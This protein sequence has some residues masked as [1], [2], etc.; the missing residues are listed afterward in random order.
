MTLADFRQT[1]DHETAPAGLGEHLL[2]MWYEARGEWE[3]AHDIAQ[4]VGT[5]EG[6]WIHAYLYRKEGDEG[7]AAYWYRRAGRPFPSGRSLDEEWEELVRHFLE[8]GQ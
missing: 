1:L 6:D 3:R 8:S 7:N 5:E 2:A 4:N